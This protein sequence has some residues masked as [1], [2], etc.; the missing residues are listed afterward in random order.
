M[1]PGRFC[2]FNDSVQYFFM[3]FCTSDNS[4]FPDFLPARFELRLDQR[5]HSSVYAHYIESRRNDQTDGNKAYVHYSD[6]RCFFEHICCQIARICTFHDRNAR[7][8][9]EF[10]VQLSVS[11]IN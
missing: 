11:D 5:I 4:V 6:F 1:Q 3:G 7:I 8:I 10:P 9:P 2:K